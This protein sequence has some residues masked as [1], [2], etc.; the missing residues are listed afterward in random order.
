MKCFPAINGVALL[1]G[2]WLLKEFLLLTSLAL[3]NG[4]SD[5]YIGKRYLMVNARV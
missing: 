1:Q 4:F 5:T 3:V 2:R